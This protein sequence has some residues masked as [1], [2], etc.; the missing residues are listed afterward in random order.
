MR[1]L[2]LLALTAC[3]TPKGPWRVVGVASDAEAAQALAIVEAAKRVTPDEKGWLAMG[4]T[5]YLQPDVRGVCTSV[6]HPSG[7]ATPHALWVLH[8]HPVGG[9]DLAAGALPHE[10]CHIGL[11]SGGGFAGPV[12][13]PNDDQADACALLV[14]KEY[15]RRAP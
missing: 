4:G 6:T 11:E 14:L 9:Y 1:W 12:I 13:I 5:L 3:A 8:P 7:C 2:A 15:R 10:L